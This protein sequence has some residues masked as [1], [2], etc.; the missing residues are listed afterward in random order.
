MNTGSKIT[1]PFIQK[2][3][4]RRT[5]DPAIDMTVLSLQIVKYPPILQK[6]AVNMLLV[7]IFR[8]IAA[9]FVLLL[10]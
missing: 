1:H 9:D 10:P 7:D 2:Y 5:A 3:S 6:R 4:L 8:Q